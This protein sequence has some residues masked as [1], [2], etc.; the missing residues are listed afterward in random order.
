M[1]VSTSRK[2][3]HKH[4]VPIVMITM[5]LLTLSV[6]TLGHYHLANMNSGVTLARGLVAPVLHVKPIAKGLTHFTLDS[7]ATT[8][9]NVGVSS[10]LSDAFTQAGQAAQL[11]F[12][13]Q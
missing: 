4:A 1:E 11:S 7:S 9:T 10:S 13:F 8:L 3:L 12:T 2:Q 6:L 5:G